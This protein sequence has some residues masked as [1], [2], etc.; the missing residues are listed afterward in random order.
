MEKVLRITGLVCMGLSLAGAIIWAGNGAGWWT[1]EHLESIT[2]PIVAC[3][4]I[5]LILSRIR[6][7]EKE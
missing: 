7:P 6:L 2:I 4:V 1:F 3:G 5:G